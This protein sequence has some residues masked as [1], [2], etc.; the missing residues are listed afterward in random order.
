MGNGVYGLGQALGIN[1]YAQYQNH[2]QQ[3]M[4]MAQCG[5]GVATARIETPMPVGPKINDLL[6]LVEEGEE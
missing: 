5:A 1:P 3:Y 4:Q 6:L 2:I